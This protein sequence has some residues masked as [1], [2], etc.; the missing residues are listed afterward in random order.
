MEYSAVSQ[1]PATFCSFIQRGTDS[2]T[3]AVQ[4]TSVLP[5]R[6]RTE[7]AAFAAMSHWQERGRRSRKERPS[8]RELIG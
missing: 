3:V 8:G 2:S 6:S 7:P 1:P 5:Q 4:M